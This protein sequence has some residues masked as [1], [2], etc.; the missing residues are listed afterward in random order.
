MTG[1]N[2]IGLYCP[3]TVV[4]YVN[5]NGFTVPYFEYSSLRS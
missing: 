5:Y 2:A 3:Y 1:R 4:K